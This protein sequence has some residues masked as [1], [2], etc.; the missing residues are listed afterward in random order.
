MLT[1]AE[2][3]R[4]LKDAREAA[5]ISLESAAAATGLSIDLVR[6]CE[7]GRDLAAGYIAKLA[8]TYG[9]SEEG[10]LGGDV[11]ETSVSVLFRG[12]P[13]ADDLAAHLGR[14][15]A[16][17]REQTQLE[18]LLGIPARGRVA[19]FAPAGPPAPP[20]W[21]QSEALAISTRNELDL[22]VAPIRSMSGLF[23]ELGIRL[24]WTDRLP[25]E[26]QGVSL[27]D[28]EV[29]PSVIANLNG[30]RHLWWTLRSTLAHELCH[31]LYDRQPAAPL[32]IASRRDQRDDLEQRANAF[33]V[34]FLAPREGV[35]R[36]LMARG[37]RPYELERTDVHAVMSHFGL[38]KEAATAH[39]MHLDWITGEQRDHL[40]AH[41]YPAEPQ[42]DAESP[43]VQPDW[44]PYLAL[45][46]Q[47]ER[48]SVVR[49]AERAYERGVITLGRLREALGLSPF[50]DLEAALTG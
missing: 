29:G 37:C 26:V 44:A 10:L 36:L 50:A 6:R 25:E 24:V 23:E 7:Q 13:R 46:V 33:G 5:H 49:T 41:R 21:R 17:C 31:I 48:L 30:R 34:Y 47:L 11:R 18:D 4:R 20:P 45:G 16:I 19:G 2:I 28:P 32:G 27:H 35:R 42:D 15:A 22:G 9:Y 12:D 3:G 1:A 8:A 40:L 14:L 38:G 43:D 39:L